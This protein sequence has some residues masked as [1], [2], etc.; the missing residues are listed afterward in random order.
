MQLCSDWIR[1][2]FHCFIRYTRTF[3]SSGSIPV[4]L[5]EDAVSNWTIYRR[6]I[7]ELQGIW[8]EAAVA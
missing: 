4:Y 3:L 1:N 7:D 2:G 8:K 6:V 5:F